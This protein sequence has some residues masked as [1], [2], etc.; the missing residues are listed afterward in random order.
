MITILESMLDE[1]E[2]KFT[3][4]YASQLYNEHPHKYNMLGLHIMLMDY[5]IQSKG[6]HYKEK[7]LKGL[8]YPCILHVYGDFVVACNYDND[9]IM[10]IWHGQKI[11]KTVDEFNKIWTG[12]ALL[13]E[14]CSD[15]FEPEY[16]SHKKAEY[17]NKFMELILFFFPIILSL[18]LSCINH[19]WSNISTFF[20]QILL[21]LGC[22]V[23]LMLVQKQLFK[24]SKSADRICSLFKKSDCNNVLFSPKSKILGMISLSEIGLGF[25]IT[26]IFL[27]AF[28]PKD[29]I[30]TYISLW[31]AMPFAF[32]SIWYQWRIIKQWC[33]LCVITQVII[34]ISGAVAIYSCVTNENL[35]FVN[36]EY[37]FFSY[38]LL[39]ISKLLTFLLIIT[40][41]H[42]IS[43]FIIEKQEASRIYQNFRSFKSNIDV[44]NTKIHQMEK[45]DISLLDSSIIF[46]NPSAKMR[47]TVVSNPHCNPCAK[48]H[49]RVKKIIGKNYSDICIQYIFTSFSNDL[50]ESSKFLIAVYQQK[51]SAEIAYI[52][53]E[54][55]KSGK[56]ITK[57][58]FEKYK[59]NITDE[60][61][62]EEMKRQ[63]SWVERSGLSATPTIIVNNFKLPYD[64]YEIED[65]LQL[66]E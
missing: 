15:A 4:S 33:T 28:I 14:D 63:K 19:I 16:N 38:I 40:C 39:T 49:E 23:C 2:V 27:I 46:G 55:F 56:F 41:I 35:L 6:I 50:E 25:F 12:N 61:V 31:L 26:N 34:W 43:N 59:V 52:Y 51:T 44:F 10:Y 5:N 17:L 57:N 3:R 7:E 65:L 36:N 54:W 37:D 22:F 47:V 1:L 60:Q 13:I 30:V 29:L 64:D 53:D 62:E 48:M 8:V 24:I 45:Y 42:Y 18:I 32:W 9:Q 58:F 66:S 20:I 11:I 21:I